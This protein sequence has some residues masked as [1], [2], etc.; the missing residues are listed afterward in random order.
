MKI[1]F[2]L[3]YS[4][5]LGENIFVVGDIPELGNGD[6]SKALPMQFFNE[7]EW[8][9]EFETKKKKFE[10]T[11]FVRNLKD[12]SIREEWAPH[13]FERHILSKNLIVRDFWNIPVLPQYNLGTTLFDE[14]SS[15]FKSQNLR[16]L[17]KN[18][19]RFKIHFPVFNPHQVLLLTGNTPKLGEWDPKRGIEM[20]P[21]GKNF[22]YID[23]AMP[24]LL[25]DFEY[26]YAL[27]DKT[28]KSVKFFET[29]ANRIGHPVGAEDV[30]IYNDVCFRVPE[31]DRWRLS[32][33]AIPVFSIRTKESCGV[34]EFSD[35]KALGKWAKNAGFSLIQIL[36]INDTTAHY[37]W[38]DCYPY[39]AISVFALH[40]MYLSLK[41][42]PYSLNK[43]EI[44]SLEKK[45]KILNQSSGVEYEAVN[46]YKRDF[47][48]KYF[49]RNWQ[50]IARDKDFLSFKKNNKNWL[51]PYA[52]FSSL[53]D[54]YG[55]TNFEQW[56]AYQQPSEELMNC[57]NDEQHLLHAAV[58]YYCF[59]QW[60]LD[61]QLRNAVDFLHQ[62][63]VGLKGDLPI[64]ISRHSVD[65]W[66]HRE[67][68]HM[69]QQAGAPPDD[70]AVLGQNWEFPTYN[71][72]KMKDDDY[73]WWKSRFQF[74][75][76][77][78]DAF[79]I[80]HILGFFR[81]WQ[82]PMH[83]TQGILGYF[84]PALAFSD[85]ELRERG[86]S[87]SI[88]RLTQPFVTKEILKQIFDKEFETAENKYFKTLEDEISLKEEF[89]TQR[90]I[91]QNL[92]SN[93]PHF[94]IL[95]NLVANVLFI[96]DENRAEH[97]HPRFNL[98]ETLSYQDLDE[99]HKHVL[100][101]LYTDYFY[102]RNE[103]FWKIKGLEKLP[104]LKKATNMLTCGEDLGLIPKVVPEV[105]QELAVLNLEI[106]RMPGRVDKLFTHPADSPYLCV[107]S[108]S[109]H[110]TSTLR[111]WWKENRAGIKFFYNQWM[112][113]EG[114]PPQELSEPLQEEI[115][116]QHLF[117][118]AMLSIIPIQ[119][120]LGIDSS[121]RNPKEDDERIN[122][123]SVFPH[124]W[125]YRMHISVEDLI[126]NKKFT[127]KL[128]ALN[129]K[130]GRIKG[131]IIQ[132]WK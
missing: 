25:C 112:G 113:H 123:P 7:S 45:S 5:H 27:Y 29:G 9:V 125:D 34:G 26:K 21:A 31:L 116:H 107:V 42:L 99:H 67:L 1:K 52:V 44:L 47:T 88:K 81:I 72:S 53:R 13:H 8:Y 4:T 122:I 94:E 114:E 58:N 48:Q 102:H 124:K 86:V 100:Y 20:K 117:S 46:Q 121:T 118:P 87:L 83:A 30:Q 66:E 78:F 39:A 56:P 127:Q 132:F 129:Q 63:G 37:S 43:K 103:D 55:T 23:V 105:M 89:S 109:S 36:P 50:K 51:I 92:D 120:F 3:K 71:W 17:K 79:R 6:K 131:D 75:A 85:E 19:H 64:G 91:Q 95:M 97:F 28:E 101:L 93:H 2:H 77:Y 126:E 69:N 60:I 111:Q 119:E 80:D 82:I 106:Q 24:A 84:E 90:K 40:P 115:L 98:I 15:Q 61:M 108:P 33:L 104:M 73:T 14:I 54:E 130:C 32:G 128:N 65:A 62:E 96:E 76:R 70:F 11:Y 12:S 41:E 49:K 59:I 35:L 22:W 110:D 16:A 74:M 10:Y 68:F 38:L 18:T 57:I